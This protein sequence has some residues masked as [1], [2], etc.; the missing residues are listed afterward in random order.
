MCWKIFFYFF[1]G[2]E[3][4]YVLPANQGRDTSLID[5]NKYIIVYVLKDIYV[6]FLIG[7]EDWYVLPANRS[8]DTSLIDINKYIIVHVLKDIYGF[9][10]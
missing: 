4:W 6:V 1:I 7:S 2:S 8:R 3:D 9:F 10:F 5:I